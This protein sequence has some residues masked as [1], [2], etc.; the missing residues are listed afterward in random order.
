MPRKRAVLQVADTGPL[1]SLVV[2]LEEAG[3]ECLLPGPKLRRELSALGGLVLAPEDLQASMGYEPPK[4]LQRVESLRNI[5]LYVDVKA[6]QIRERFTKQYGIPIL[7]YRINGGQPEHVPGRGDEVNPGCPILTPNQWY[8]GREDAY[9]FWPYFYRFDRYSRDL[10]VDG[11]PICLIHNINGWGYQDLVPHMRGLG[12]RCYGRGS[13]DGLVQ[14]KDVPYLLSRAL[15]TVHLKSND[16]PGYAI[17]ES[18]ASGCPIVCTRRLIWRC[19]MQELL[20]PNETCLVFD[21]ETHD[22]LTSEDVASCVADVAT[23]LYQ[24]KDPAVNRGI[25]EAGRQKLLDLMWED[26]EGFASWMRRMFP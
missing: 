2:M 6:H 9:A 11:P 1:E 10:I 16:A 17:Y 13:P 18:M 23:H 19:K 26:A 4:D 8:K 3:Y 20:I 21:R 5:D 12:V 15:C 25:G 14:H 7:W 22:A 24:L